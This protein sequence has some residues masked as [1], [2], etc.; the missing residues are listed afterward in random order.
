MEGNNI[1]GK[2]VLV[3]LARNEIAYDASFVSWAQMDEHLLMADKMADFIDRQV[4]SAVA[5]LQSNISFA[6]VEQS[7]MRTNDI[8]GH[9][10]CWPIVL[11]FP[12]NWRGSADLM[13]DL[14]H[15]YVAGF[16]TLEWLR[17]K[18]K[19]REERR[20]VTDKQSDLDDALR[21]VIREAY[22]IYEPCPAWNVETAN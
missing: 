18:A 3:E 12:E 7:Q 1:K 21:D 4:K 8:D 9:P 13:T 22:K 6:R 19:N 17:A 10:D 5:K 2:E 11:V 20:V 16:V 14:A 15:R